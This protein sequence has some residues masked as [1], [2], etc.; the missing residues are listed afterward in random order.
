MQRVGAWFLIVIAFLLLP[1][2]GSAPTRS[3]AVP[4]ELEDR[5]TV[6]D[7]PGIRY[8]ADG[9]TKEMANLGIEARAR[10]QTYWQATGHT[11]ALPPANLLAI[12]G[13]GENGAF[14][15]GLLVGWTAAG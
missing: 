5:A 6:G 8:W 1:A 2:C 7:M 10:E 3:E 13:G 15:A 14:G 9:D 11:G 4:V 12:S